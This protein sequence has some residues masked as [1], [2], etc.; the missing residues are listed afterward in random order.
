MNRCFRLFVGV[1]AL[2]AMLAGVVMAEDAPK[3]YKFTLKNIESGQ[4]VSLDSLLGSTPVVLSFAQTACSMCR[5]EMV[6]LK[7]FQNANVGKIKVVVIL[8]DLKPSLD[9]VKSLKK[10]YMLE[11]D[12]LSDPA[13]KVPDAYGFSYTP[14]A[15]LL[16]KEGKVLEQ[17]GG[18]S[19][20]QKIDMKKKLSAHL[21]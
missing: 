1:F 18:F 14:A 10:D 20:S 5:E 15:V 17:F 16:D 13:F 3:I 4:D 19:T 11:F 6:F 7:E 2:T 8:A 9:L 12:F 21:K